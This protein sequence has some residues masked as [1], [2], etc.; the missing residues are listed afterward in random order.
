[1]GGLDKYP[2]NNVSLLTG[3]DFLAGGFSGTKSSL[4]FTIGTGYVDFYNVRHPYLQEVWLPTSCVDDGG[5][6]D[7]VGFEL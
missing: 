7:R 5:Q 3:G 6:S 2:G 1:M 4:V